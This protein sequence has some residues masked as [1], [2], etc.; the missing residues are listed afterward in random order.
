LYSRIRYFIRPSWRIPRKSLAGY[1]EAGAP[2]STYRVTGTD[3]R[4]DMLKDSKA[5]SG[6]STDDVAASK[7]FYGDTLGLDLTEENGMIMLHLAGDRDTLI[8]PKPGHVPATYTVL[9]FPVAD[10]DAAVDELT[11]KGVPFEK[12]EGTDEKGIQR[13]YGPTIAWFT[14]PAGNILSVIGDN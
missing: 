4:M 14:D 7:A 11:A 1:V 9:N 8:Y 12:Y 6:F 10:V 5:F 3:G 2:V 13:G